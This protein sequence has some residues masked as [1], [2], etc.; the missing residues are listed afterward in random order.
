VEWIQHYV[1]RVTTVARIQVQ[2]AQ[3][4]MTQ[5]QE[6]MGNVKKGRLTTTQPE[7][8][9]EKMLNCIGNS[10]SDLACSEDEEDV[11]DKDVDDEDTGHGKLNDDDEPG[12]LI[13]KISKPV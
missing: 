2:D 6:H 10:L 7:I 13:C 3:T 5:E 9:F 12:W 4:A 1:D 11:E 8:T